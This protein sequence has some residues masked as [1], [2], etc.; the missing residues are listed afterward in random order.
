MGQAEQRGQPLRLTL[1]FDDLIFSNSRLIL[2]AQLWFHRWLPVDY[3]RPFPD[4]DTVASYRLSCY[5]REP[6][7][8][9]IIGERPGAKITRAKVESGGALARIRAREIVH[10]A[11]RQ[12]DSSWWRRSEAQ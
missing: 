12:D 6:A 8:A 5:R 2:A 10:D 11:R 1:G 3:L 9:L 4:G 7:N